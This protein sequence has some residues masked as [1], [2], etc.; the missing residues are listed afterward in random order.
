MA[1]TGFSDG[2]SNVNLVYRSESDEYS[3]MPDDYLLRVSN[4]DIDEGLKLD[5]FTPI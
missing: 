4:I 2:L 5:S 1:S 3:A